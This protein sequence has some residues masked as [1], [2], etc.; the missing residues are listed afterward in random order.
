[1]ITYEVRRTQQGAV[2]VEAKTDNELETTAIDHYDDLGG[3]LSVL[4]EMSYSLGIAL[5]LRHSTYDSEF[6]CTISDP[7]VPYGSRILLNVCSGTSCSCVYT[8]MYV[9]DVMCRRDFDT[10]LSM[11]EGILEESNIQEVLF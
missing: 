8:A 7:K 1:M 4:P 6:Q 9:Y 11:A 3:V 10:V 2:Y 5:T